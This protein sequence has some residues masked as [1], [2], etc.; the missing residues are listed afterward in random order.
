MP[1]LRWF[2]YP[3]AALVFALDQWSKIVATE[4]LLYA[5][6]VAVQPWLNWLLVHN[7]GAA[8]SF[9]ANAGGW[10][11]WFFLLLGFGVGTY[12]VISLWRLG[13]SQWL[14][15]LGYASILGGACGNVLD[16]ARLGYVVDFIQVHYGDNYW[17]AFNLADSAITL[18]VLLWFGQLWLDR[19]SATAQEAT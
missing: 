8:F 14:L 18:G 17:P 16:R 7:R 10:Q 12:L 2:C 5:E 15:A 11:R 3:L 9:L 4:Y 1:I 19:S 6:P 13:R